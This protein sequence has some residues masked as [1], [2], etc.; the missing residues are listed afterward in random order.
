M[1]VILEI[2]IDLLSQ[3]GAEPQRIPTQRIAG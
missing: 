1:E 2:E 3:D